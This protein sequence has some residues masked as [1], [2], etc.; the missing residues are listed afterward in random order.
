MKAIVTSGWG[1]NTK[2]VLGEAASPT[3]L[4]ADDV[5]VQVHAASV[6]PKDYKLNYSAAVLLTPPVV[7]K[8]APIF[9]D[10]LAGIVIDKG[11]NVSDFEIGDAVYGM[12]MRPH[13]RHRW[14]NK[15]A[16]SKSVSPKNQRAFLLPRRPSCHWPR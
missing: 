2:L 15:H 10:D 4:D 11:S 1:L 16:L 3:Q 9:G 5:L 14:L 6:N 13:E 12:D 8:M 7:R